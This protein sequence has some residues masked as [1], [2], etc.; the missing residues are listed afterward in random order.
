MV[1]V[2]SAPGGCDTWLQS[3]AWGGKLHQGDHGFSIATCRK[4][5]RDSRTA[6][7]CEVRI[8]LLNI[9]L[10]KPFL[11]IFTISTCLVGQKRMCHACRWLA[12]HPKGVPVS[13]D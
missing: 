6:E 13:P 1:A 8:N 2:T 5:N 11:S 3:Y 7:E 4:A 10:A 12:C 9:T